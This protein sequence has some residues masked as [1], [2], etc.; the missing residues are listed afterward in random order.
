M[1]EKI[2]VKVGLFIHELTKE[3]IAEA[4]EDLSFLEN[5]VLVLLNPEFCEKSFDIPYDKKTTI[6]YLREYFERRP[7]WCEDFIAK[8]FNGSVQI[9]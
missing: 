4:L 3:E 9:K 8:V 2:E 6:Q 7:N 5:S 1:G